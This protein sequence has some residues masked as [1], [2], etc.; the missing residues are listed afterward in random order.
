MKV[1]NQSIL[2]TKHLLTTNSEIIEF[3]PE[4]NDFFKMNGGEIYAFIADNEKISNIEDYAI[5]IDPEDTELLDEMDYDSD[6][7]TVISRFFVR[8]L[9]H[10]EKPDIEIKPTEDKEIFITNEALELKK[11]GKGLIKFKNLDD[12]TKLFEMNIMNN[13]LTKPLYEIMNLLNK[14][15]A[16]SIDETIDEV[17]QQFLE[18]L[19]KSKINANV[20]AAE[21]IINRL[22]RSVENPL[23]R[24]DF[25]QEELEPYNI[26]TVRQA[27]EKNGSPLIG[28]SFQDLKKQLLSDE[29]YETR[30]RE[31]YIDPFFKTEI[32]MKNLKEYSKICET[33]PVKRRNY[34]LIDVTRNAKNMVHVEK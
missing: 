19:I 17:C 32:P 4:F 1:V 6:F 23:D 9:K 30:N 2:S 22:I 20:I 28:L 13:E 21:L 7:N 31:S 27:L 14:N 3:N 18:L 34:K 24:P 29:I 10:P 8:D 16:D 12:E 5:Y 25:S 26:L 11:K 33:Q 15:K